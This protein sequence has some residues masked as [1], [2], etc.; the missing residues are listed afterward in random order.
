MSP[1]EDRGSHMTAMTRYSRYYL[2]AACFLLLTSFFLM[3]PPLKYCR[4][5][6][7]G[8]RRMDRRDALLAGVLTLVYA[9]CAFTGL[10]N[11]ESPQSFV[12]MQGRTA[13]MTLDLDGGMVSHLMLFTGV[14]IG[15]YEIRYTTNGQDD[16]LLARFVQN[17]AD[18]LKWHDVYSDWWITGGTIRIRG[19]GN[20]WLGE[21]AALTVDGTRVALTSE[22]AALCDEQDTLPAKQNFMNSAYF[23]EIY[24]ARTA[25]EQL[26]SIWPYEITHPPLGKTI[27]GLG[28]RLFGMTPFGW[29]FSGTLCGVLMLP[30]LYVLAKKLFGGRLAPA[31]C[32]VLMATDFMHFVQ[33]RISTI[34]VYAVFFILLMYLFMYLFVGEGKLWA[35]ALS[36][37]CFGLGA[38]SKWTCFYAGA[39]LA[40]LWAIWAVESAK[41]GALSWKGFLKNCG[42]CVVFFILVPAL[43]YD[44]AYLPYGRALG[45]TNPFS[46]GYIRMVLDNQN[47]MFTYHSG[48]VATHP[49]ASRWYQWVLDIRPILYYLEYFSNGTHSSFGAWVNPVLCWGGLLA[50]FVLAYLALVRRDRVSRFILIGYLAQLLPWIPVTRLTF[51]YH[52]FPCT[53]FLALALGRC[54]SVMKLNVMRG[55]A[56]V[57]CFAALSLAVFILFYPSLAGTPVPNGFLRSWLPTWPF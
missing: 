52:Y 43:I 23:D 40:V 28:V 18:V 4:L 16:Y 7:G 8:S 15:T 53:V 3:L 55:R 20:V 44:L 42:F 5:S 45:Y 21:V 32:T 13:E 50:L 6:E 46:R 51:A 22:D 39:G 31:A 19:S 30:L 49:Y 35:L 56:Y 24:H 25:W 17:S 11:T 54:F 57:A 9:L 10:G 47:Y 33:T 38:A 14:G 37:V 1:R 48:L 36:G 34:D 41:S 27:I 29:R 26:K 12:N 2:P